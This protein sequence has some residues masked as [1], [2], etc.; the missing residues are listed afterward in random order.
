MLFEEFE[1]ALHMAVLAQTPMPTPNPSLQPV[2]GCLVRLMDGDEIPGLLHNAHGRILPTISLYEA[3]G[4]QLVQTET[5]H[6]AGQPWVFAGEGRNTASYETSRLVCL[7]EGYPTCRQGRV[8]EVDNLP[9]LRPLLALS[10]FM[11]ISCNFRDCFR[12]YYIA[13]MFR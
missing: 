11:A 6:R 5:A 9:M 1:A 3:P 10:K 7:D 2:A 12:P 13:A 8:P 4:H